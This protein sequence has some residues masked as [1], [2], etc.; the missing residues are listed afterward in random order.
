MTLQEQVVAAAR[1]EIGKSYQWGGEDNPGFDCSGLTQWCYAQVGISIPRT[2]QEQATAGIPVAYSDLQLGDLIII[3]PDAS[4]VA[5]Y[6][7]GGNVIQAADYGI[8][9]EEVPI[10]QAGPYNCARR[11][12]NQENT[13]TLFYP[14]VSNNN[15]NSGQQ[16][17]DFLAQLHPEGFAG[18]CHKVSEGNYYGDPYW[19]TC[20]A[21]CE[22]NDLSWLGY[23]YVTT[24]DPSAQA[25]MWLA[26]N[27]G[28]FAMLDFEANSGDINNF[29]RVV[30]AFNNI[31]VD[32]SMAYIPRWYW[33]E[34]G[35]P[36]LSPLA[37][38]QISLVSSS[39]PAGNGYASS[40]YNDAG[41]DGG[42]GWAP[43]GGAAPTVW[44]FTDR[45]NIAG[46]NVDCN[47]YNG[48][49]ADLNLDALFTGNVFQS[50][51]NL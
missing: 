27:G 34:I 9:V 47:A 18:V 32:V 23:H 48:P 10:A 19:E 4:H 8:P 28:P 24:N 29:W 43:Y 15:W 41:G 22:N 26:N 12:I 1:G 2:S 25:G 42:N 16:L 6:S 33:Q 35:S 13:V 37:A 30:E 38:N 31:N 40:I 36:D 45:A 11:I 44:Q 39:Y 17:T 46:I 20:R 50:E 14:D 21:W 3:Y 49:S 5:M 51:G 7:G